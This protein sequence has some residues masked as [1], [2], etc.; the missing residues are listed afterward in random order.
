MELTGC[1]EDDADD[2]AWKTLAMSVSDAE[3]V[4]VEEGE[5]QRKSTKEEVET[6]QSWIKRSMGHLITRPKVKK[7][8]FK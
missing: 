6:A 7:L 1:T 2:L 8:L 4:L 5:M 3:D